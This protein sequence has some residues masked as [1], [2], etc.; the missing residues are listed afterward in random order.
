MLAPE[1]GE[2][3]TNF[4]VKSTAGVKVEVIVYYTAPEVVKE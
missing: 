3:K 1:V 4:A 2:E